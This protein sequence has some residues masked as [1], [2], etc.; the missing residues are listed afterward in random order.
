MPWPEDPSAR[1]ESSLGDAADGPVDV[2][3]VEHQLTEGGGRNTV[4]STRLVDVRS[5]PA[6]QAEWSAGGPGQVDADRHVELA[7][8][9]PVDP[10]E[11][12]G[13][14]RH[15]VAVAM[16][17][18]HVDTIRPRRQADRRSTLPPSPTAGWSYPWMRMIRQPFWTCTRIRSSCV[19]VSQGSGA[20]PATSEALVV[21]QVE[22]VDAPRVAMMPGPSP[23][24]TRT[25]GTITAPSGDGQAGAGSWNSPPSPGSTEGAAGWIDSRANEGIAG[26]DEL[27][28]EGE[29]EDDGRVVAP[30]AATSSAAAIATTIRDPRSIGSL[31]VRF[32]GPP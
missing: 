17:N 11:P 5:G 16:G 23:S 13:P 1:P 29:T 8:R 4:T 24:E 27:E 26:C 25:S 10:D 32:I 19:A 14:T 28:G 12:E 30:H 15:G 31:Y 2:R 3:V 6:T 7:D 21:V 9:A 22:N 18:S 20:S